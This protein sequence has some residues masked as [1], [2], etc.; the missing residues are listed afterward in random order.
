MDLQVI[1][2]VNLSTVLLTLVMRGL[3]Y[4]GEDRVDNM[5]GVRIR[6]V[7]TVSNARAFMTLDHV[8]ILIPNVA[9]FRV[10]GEGSAEKCLFHVRGKGEDSAER[11]WL[12]CLQ[13]LLGQ[14]VPTISHLEALKLAIIV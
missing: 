4:Y 9:V 1:W 5:A 11:T 3:R 10:H 6:S 8:V 7:Y 2:G 12:Q 13:K 14:L